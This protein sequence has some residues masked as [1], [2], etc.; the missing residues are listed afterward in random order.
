MKFTPKGKGIHIKLSTKKYNGQDYISISV[1]DEGIGI[2]ID[3][4]QIIFERFGQADTSMSRQ[5]EGTGLGLH[6]V[7][8][9]V[10]ALK[11][12]ISIKS[13]VGCG[14]TFTILLPAR[15]QIDVSET[16]TDKEIICHLFD[17]NSR[18]IQATSIEFSDIYFD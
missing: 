18:I 2:P 11:G 4:Q 12:E 14:S 15:N 16:A 6:L 10:D 8:L 7:K 5:A 3:K 17:M 1:V 13:K 9:L